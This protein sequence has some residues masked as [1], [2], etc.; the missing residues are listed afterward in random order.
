MVQ[1]FPDLICNPLRVPGPSSASRALVC[2]SCGWTN[3]PQPQPNGPVMVVW[4]VPKRCGR[5]DRR[6]NVKTGNRD[7]N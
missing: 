1:A 7:R 3:Y 6:L 5:C 4:E 2:P